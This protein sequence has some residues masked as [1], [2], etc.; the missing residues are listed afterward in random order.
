MKRKRDSL[1]GL[2]G[3]TTG[4]MGVTSGLTALSFGAGAVSTGNLSSLSL[5]GASAVT[6]IGFSEAVRRKLRRIK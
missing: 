5:A 2:M 6:S 3:M 1:G 4:F